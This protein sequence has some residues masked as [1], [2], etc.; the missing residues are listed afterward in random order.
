VT[1]RLEARLIFGVLLAENFA[2]ERSELGAVAE[3]LGDEVTLGVDG[4]SLLDHKH[5][6]QPVGDQ[7]KDGEEWQEAGFRLG[8]EW[9]AVLLWIQHVSP[10]MVSHNRR[11][12]VQVQLAHQYLSRR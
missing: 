2:F 3:Q 7:K 6:Q 1:L 5:G 12:Q 8:R 4:A 11:Q 10:L 9:I